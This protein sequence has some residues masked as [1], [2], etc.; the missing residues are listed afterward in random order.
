MNS[1]IVT[2]ATR[3]KEL[4][5]QKEQVS[6]QLK[7]INVEL[8]RI[9]LT[10]IPDAMA[11]EGIKTLTIDGIGR[12]GLTADVYVSYAGQQEAAFEWLHDNGFGNCISEQANASTLKSIFRGFIR[13]GKDLPVDIFKITPFTRASITKA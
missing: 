5:D 13:D 3:M 4:Q 6:E 2:L 12:V 7:A 9:R 10:D 8:D 1:E 11:E